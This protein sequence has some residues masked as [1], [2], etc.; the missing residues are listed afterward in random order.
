MDYLS[1]RHLLCQAAD[2]GHLNRSRCKDYLMG[3]GSSL[4]LLRLL[5]N[6]AM[7]FMDKEDFMQCWQ[8]V[9]EQLFEFAD[10]QGDEMNKHYENKNKSHKKNKKQ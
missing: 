8:K 2:N 4:N 1:Y 9:G 6:C 10:E 3:K 5:I 7:V